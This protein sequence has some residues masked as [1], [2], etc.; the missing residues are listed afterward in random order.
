[1]RFPETSAVGIPHPRVPGLVVVDEG[2]A[3]KG[4]RDYFARRFLDGREIETY[5]ALATRRQ[6]DWLSGRIAAKD[7][8]RHHLWQAGVGP[9]FPIE[10]EVHV[11]ASGRPRIELAERLRPRALAVS[12]AHKH[13]L[14]AAL[15]R[16]AR[17]VGLDVERVEP[18]DDAFLE[19]AFAPAERALFPAAPGRAR[20]EAIARAWAAK[21]ALGKRRGSGLEHNPRRLV[22]GALGPAGASGWVEVD[23]DGVR[24][25][26]LVEDERV[27]A[28]TEDA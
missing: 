14:A 21:E 6:I 25:E 1:M 2:F 11:E 28:W 24:V 22:V 7:A 16:D 13:G 12:I 4:T 27:W 23:V 17:A 26:T 19:L 5:D 10:V 20:D 18:R 15:V 9:I 3:S 8:V